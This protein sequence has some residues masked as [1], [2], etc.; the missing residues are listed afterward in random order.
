VEELVEGARASGVRHVVVTGGEPLL[1]REIGALT[2]GL[3][4]AGLHV[5]VETAGTVDPLF[6]CDL[7]SLSPK[8]ANSDPSDRHRDRHRR[9]RLDLTPAI[10][11]LKVFPEHQLKFVVESAD[12][13]REILEMLANFGEIEPARVLL[14]AQGRTLEEAAGRAPAVA[15]LCL[16]HGFRYTPRLHLDLFGGGRG[17]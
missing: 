16:E 13:L 3:A 8:T 1:Q 5:T 10:R 2:A 14:M 4:A 9:L 7:L 17:V 12:D 15:A 11:L 6:H